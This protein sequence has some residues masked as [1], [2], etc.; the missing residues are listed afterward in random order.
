MFG[1][2]TILSSSINNLKNGKLLI[3]DAINYTNGI[4]V[5]CI[6]TKEKARVSGF[7]VKDN[8][9]KMKIFRYV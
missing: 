7:Y 1:N 6:S 3:K 5:L 2:Y 8:N 9:I 4:P